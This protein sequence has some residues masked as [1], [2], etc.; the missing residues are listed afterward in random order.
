MFVTYLQ[1]H[2]VI[3]EIGILQFESL[4]IVFAAA[5]IVA[6][7]EVNVKNTAIIPSQRTYIFT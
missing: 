7:Y 4:L 6:A 2:V 1:M 5:D 3:A